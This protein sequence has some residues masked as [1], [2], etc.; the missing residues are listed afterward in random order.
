MLPSNINIKKKSKYRKKGKLSYSSNKY[1]NPFFIKKKKSN[2]KKLV[3]E[4]AVKRIRIAITS[5]SIV[6]IGS[7]W[8]LFYSNYFTINNIVANGG[9]RISHDTIEKYAWQQIND[10]FIIFLPQKNIFIFSK[11]KL[12]KNL[13]EKYS[14]NSLEIVKEL[15]ST[16]IVNYNEKQYAMIWCED[17]KYFYSDEKGYVITEAN[18]LEIKQKD[19]PIIKN[20]TDRR[21]SD[22]QV[23]TGTDYIN[24][25]L[26]LF[27]KF[28]NYDT[29]FEID[30]FIIDND[31]NTVKAEIREGP[32]IYFNINE[33]IEKQFNKL[34]I[35]KKEKIKDSFYSKSYID[36]RIGDSV[37]YR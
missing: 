8:F 2:K 16:L 30:R 37:Y 20:N 10:S 24:Y 29:E 12:I 13:E 34:L 27:E 21:I 22:D 14:F 32:S 28:K 11:S 18:L 35:I 7:V 4:T 33:D 15:P 9:G 36:V 31:I 17:D 19:Y 6:V 26:A 3:S 25:I 1:S 23:P 5:A